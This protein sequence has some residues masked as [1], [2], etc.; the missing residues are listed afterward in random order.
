M[1][2]NDVITITLKGENAKRYFLE[3]TTEK[4]GVRFQ[5]IPKES[6]ILEEIG[7]SKMAVEIFK[8]ALEMNFLED[9]EF[10]VGK[11]T[12][13]TEGENV[14][15]ENLPSSTKG[16]PNRK[17]LG[18]DQREILN[19]MENHKGEE[20][21]INNLSIATNY[22]KSKLRTI[23]PSLVK[24]NL[25]ERK[26]IKNGYV[27][28]CIAEN[29]TV[30]EKVELIPETTEMESDQLDIED[31]IPMEKTTEETSETL[32]EKALAKQ[33][34]ETKQIREL[35]STSKYFHILNNT[36]KNDTFSVEAI[37]RKC[38]YEEATAL[39]EVIR[40]LS[41]EAI[42]YSPDDDDI[43]NVNI[44]WRTYAL[45]RLGQ[46]DIETEKSPEIIALLLAKGLIYEEPEG[47]YNIVM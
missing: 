17:G 45:I 15:S 32:E 18:D 28:F 14:E 2:E 12:E 34:T 29:D 6:L 19:F 16:T 3:R 43:Y 47:K 10:Q 46:K 31:S 35:F 4:L 24:R 33:S 27:Y 38:N 41:G 26:K 36:F 39:T 20:F 37:R 25:I 40:V 9:V 21:S 7:D 22:I 1:K 23:L 42:Q 13:Q 8:E 5:Q 11:I 44:I 30:D